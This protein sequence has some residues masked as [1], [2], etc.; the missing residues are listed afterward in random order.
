MEPSLRWF[1]LLV[2]ATLGEAGLFRVMFGA[3]SGAR[4]AARPTA[5]R[6]ASATS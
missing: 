6:T 4:A 5:G 2:G 3:E 1:Y